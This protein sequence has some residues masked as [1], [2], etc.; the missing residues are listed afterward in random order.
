MVLSFYAFYLI[1]YE[2]YNFQPIYEKIKRKKASHAISAQVSR[3]QSS[4]S[5]PLAHAQEQAGP[6]GI[7]SGRI[8]LS[9]ESSFYPIIAKPLRTLFL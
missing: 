1:Y 7:H 5:G 2:F 6:G 3:D 8:K 9:K 4:A